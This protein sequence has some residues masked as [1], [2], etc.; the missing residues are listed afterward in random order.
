MALDARESGDNNNDDSKWAE[1]TAKNPACARFR[2]GSSFEH[3]DE[4]FDALGNSSSD[5]KSI[6]NESEISES[7]NDDDDLHIRRRPLAESP[8]S[9]NGNATEEI[10]QAANIL[11]DK[12][13]NFGD[14]LEASI[15]QLCEAFLAKTVHKKESVFKYFKEGMPLAYLMEDR[16]KRNKIFD[17]FS[18]V[19]NATFFLAI[20]DKYKEDFVED[21]IL[22]VSNTS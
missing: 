7:D 12:I 1:M 9:A 17:F 13:K 2:D 11:G 14:I 8:T 20:E 10:L 21:T 18:S 22:K 6:A 3:Y 5:G 16:E 4:I 15:S 19:D